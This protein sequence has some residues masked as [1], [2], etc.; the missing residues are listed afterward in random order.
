VLVISPAKDEAKYVE[1][2]I[3]TVA[4][5]THRPTL[6]VIVN[7]GSTDDTGALVARAARD[8]P[9]IRVVHRAAGS[10]RRVGPGVVEAFNEGLR[11]ADLGEYDFVC[12][13]DADV[14]LP[15]GYF[16][17]LLQRFATN[18]RLGT[19][20]GKCYIPIGDGWSLERS[21]D[22]FSHG[23]AKLYRRECYKAIGGFVREVMWDGID[24]H[25]CRTLGW[26]ARSFD[27]PGLAIRH[28]RQMGSS[29]RSVYYGRLRWGRG[30][31]FMGTHPLYLLA[32][33]AYRMFERP[34]VAGGLCILAGYL[35]AWLQRAPRYDDRPFRAHLHSWQGRKLYGHIRSAC[36]RLIGLH[37]RVA[38]RWPNESAVAIAP[39]SQGCPAA[40]GG[41]A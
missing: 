7:D 23:V 13:L 12:K 24:C 40:K 8:H 1:R 2:T 17:D 9:W 41:K 20:S 35:Q 16:A 10:S 22:E 32:V 36:T 25:R 11:H 14:E 6:W 21:G 27:D 39:V 30:Q 26:E 34:W 38:G 31:Y 33:T 4:A 18:P 19:A 15:P 37:G 29:F 3:R 5:Q 28:L